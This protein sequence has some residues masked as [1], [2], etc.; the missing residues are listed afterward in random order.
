MHSQLSAD[1]PFGSR[2]LIHYD[3]KKP[4][5]M[6]WFLNIFAFAIRSSSNQ[7]PHGVFQQAF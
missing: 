5:G 3:T 4:A 1:R 7:H 6:D 2:K